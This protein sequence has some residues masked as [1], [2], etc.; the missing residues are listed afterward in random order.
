MGLTGTD[1]RFN[2]GWWTMLT[3]CLADW[4]VV[5]C[6]CGIV[7]T[8]TGRA[9]SSSPPDEAIGAGFVFTIGLVDC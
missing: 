7:W 3:A 8:T 5:L 6:C 4:S 2:A 1:G 9:A